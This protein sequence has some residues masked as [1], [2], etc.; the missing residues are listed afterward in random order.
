M[1]GEKRPRDG[2]EDAFGRTS[3][4]AALG[5]IGAA[6]FAGL[7]S[8]TASANNGNGQSGGNGGENGTQATADINVLENPNFITNAADEVP[9][10]NDGTEI[11]DPGPVSIPLNE[12]I[13]ENE[14]YDS[15][16]GRPLN[17]GKHQVVRPPEDYDRD[18]GY[19]D[20]W[21]AVTWGEYSEVGG[22]AIVGGTNPN[23]G[24]RVNIKVEDGIP[25]GQYTIWVVKFAALAEDSDLGPDDPF[26]TPRGN[27]LVGFHNLGQK[28]GNDGE[29]EN[30]FTVDENG[31]GEIHV[32]TE[33]GELTGIPG[34]NEPGYPFIGDA[35]DYEQDADRLSRI[36][37]DLREED[38]IHFV[39]AYHYDDQTWGVYP[40]PW[41][42]NHFSA[43]FAFDE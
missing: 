25:N 41:H 38:E 15:A 4:R 18:D 43:V 37:N 12:I 35:D 9:P 40:G 36:A 8:T 11:Y 31:N 22:H 29:S 27:A 32:F 24:T 20:S 6:G 1:D 33:G 5:F 26:V 16:L 34:F 13:E 14:E 17:D 23:K 30:D 19:V 7:A 3:R 2:N 42:V 28:F 39:G 21:E 10:F